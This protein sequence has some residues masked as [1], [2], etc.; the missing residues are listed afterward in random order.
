MQISFKRKKGTFVSLLH[1]YNSLGNKENE[2]IFNNELEQNE[3]T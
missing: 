3:P 1:L 2:N